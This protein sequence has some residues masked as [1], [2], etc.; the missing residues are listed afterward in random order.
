MIYLGH[1]KPAKPVE[2]QDRVAT[3]HPNYPAYKALEKA[4]KKVRGIKPK[5]RLE[6]KDFNDLWKK[7][8]RHFMKA[9]FEGKCAYCDVPVLSGQP[10]DVEHYRPKT[11]IAVYAKRGNR[12]DVKGKPERGKPQIVHQPGYWWLAYDWDNWLFA[13]GGCNRTWKIDQFPTQTQKKTANH[14]VKLFRANHPSASN[15][16]DVDA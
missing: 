5:T 2:F 8:K 13:C 4:R 11:Q 6:S 7:Y 1:I 12:D 14:P 15:P 16:D 10:G 3:N 9:Q